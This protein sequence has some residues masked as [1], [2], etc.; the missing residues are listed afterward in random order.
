MTTTHGALT[1]PRLLDVCCCAGGATRGYQQAGFH[2]TGVDL[3]PQPNYVGDEFIEADALEVLGDLTFVRGFDVIHASFPCQGFLKGTLH[4]PG[5]PDLVTPGRSLLTVAGVP[6]VIENVMTAPL[7]RQRS[8]ML[9]GEMFGLRTIR[10]RRFEPSPDISL[11]APPH[12]QPHRQRTAHKQRKL[13]WD[14]GWHASITGDIG[15]YAGPEAMGVDWM[16][17][18]E[19]SEAIPPAYARFVGE[20]LMAHLAE[21]SAA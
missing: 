18:N 16:T 4:K 17:G 11:T 8:I 3:D 15:T 9:C 19:L 6:W 20:Q 14:Q 12:R 10:H 1:R 2:V 7:D 21:R 13:R 5:V